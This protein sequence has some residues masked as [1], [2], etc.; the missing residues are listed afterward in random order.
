MMAA[1]LLLLLSSLLLLLFLGF[2]TS[3]F[4]FYS[5]V[6]RSFGWLVGCCC[7]LVLELRLSLLGKSGHTLLLVLGGEGGLEDTLL[8]A[9]TLSQCGLVGSV[10]GLLGKSNCNCY[11]NQ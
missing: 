11:C 4:G 2:Y 3:L 6:V 8:Q 5:L 10:D 7:L 9:E 1:P